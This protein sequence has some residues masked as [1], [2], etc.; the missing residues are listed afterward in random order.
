MTLVLPVELATIRFGEANRG[1]V[2]GWAVSCSKHGPMPVLA[3]GRTGAIV[4]AGRH[5]DHEHGGRA[6]IV[7]VRRR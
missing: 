5:R 7:E 3:P 2:T 1:R 6:R 4:A